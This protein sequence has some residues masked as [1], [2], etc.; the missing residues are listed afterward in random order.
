[1]GAD[2]NDDE[3]SQMVVVPKHAYALL[4]IEKLDLAKLGERT[5]V[6]LFNP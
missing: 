4:E 2:S 3:R 5:V 1:M 6:K